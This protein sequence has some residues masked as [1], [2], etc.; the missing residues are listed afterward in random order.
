MQES[1][2]GG[3]GRAGKLLLKRNRD[4]DD[5][6]EDWKISDVR[7]KKGYGEEARTWNFQLKREKLYG[8]TIT[9]DSSHRVVRPR[10]GS[11]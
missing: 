1:S 11:L 3:R 5:G 7:Q 9:N 6:G 4:H 10:R 2:V 8:E